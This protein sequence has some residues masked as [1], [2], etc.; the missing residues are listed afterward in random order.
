[1]EITLVGAGNLATNLG[2]VLKQAGH[3]IC[4]VYSRTENSAMALASLLDC[5]YTTDI[6]G[7]V[8][9]DIVIISVKDDALPQIGT[10]LTDSPSIVVHTAGSVP[11]NVIKCKRRGVFYPMQ[12]FSK[13]RPIDFSEIPIFLEASDEDSMNKLHAL[14][15]T[16]SRNIYSLNSEKRRYL[17]LAAVFACNF[18]NHCYHLADDI[19]KEVGLPFDVMLPL[20]DET[21]RKVHDMSPRDAQTGPAV[22]FDQSVMSKHTELLSGRTNEIYEIMSKS[23]FESHDKLRP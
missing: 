18:T 3:V 6:K 8:N 23:I 17:H 19:L 12:T 2:L 14:A 20:I 1:M 10:A 5:P 22:R 13:S 11:M 21:A 16:I 7:I 15:S 4:Q 9:S